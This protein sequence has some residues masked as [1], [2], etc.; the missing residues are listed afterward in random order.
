MSTPDSEWPKSKHWNKL[1]Q[2]GDRPYSKNCK[3]LIKEMEDDTMKWKDISCHG[4][5]EQVLK[6]P[7][8]PKAIYN[9][10]ATSIK[11]L[12]VFFTQ[13]EQYY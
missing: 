10:D 4:L 8:Y 5:E 7:Y 12:T 13:L 1:N 11:I 9:F 2:G 6:C 3:T